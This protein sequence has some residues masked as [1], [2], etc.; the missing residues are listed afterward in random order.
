MAWALLTGRHCRAGAMDIVVVPI[1][2]RLAE[3]DEALQTLRPS[4]VTWPD[5][6]GYVIDDNPTGS[7]A[8]WRVGSRRS[9]VPNQWTNSWT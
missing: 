2:D 6:A 7:E 1:N 5:P 4:V 8:S 9:L 3:S